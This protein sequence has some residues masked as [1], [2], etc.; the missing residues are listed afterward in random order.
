[1]PPLKDLNSES[2]LTKKDAPKRFTNIQIKKY[3]THTCEPYPT[4]YSKHYKHGQW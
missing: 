2:F 3:E 4:T 1:M